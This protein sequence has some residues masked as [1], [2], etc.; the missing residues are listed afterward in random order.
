MR[1]TKRKELELIKKMSMQK[2]NNGITLIALVVTVIVLL[3]LAGISI[4]ML[5]G[6]NG[7]LQRAG[8]AKD[9]TEKEGAREQIGLE[10]L[11]ALDKYGEVNLQTLKTK[12][13]EINADV[14]SI[15]DIM[16]ENA[17]TGKIT[18]NGYDFYVD[19]D[20]RVLDYNGPEGTPI[21]K[22]STE[23]AFDR[24][25][26]RIDI[27]FLNGTGYNIT[28]TPNKPALDNTMVPVYYDETNSVWKVCS[29]TD[30]IN[31]YKYE[32]EDV[33]K[34]GTEAGDT[35]KNRWANVMLTDLIQVEKDGTTYTTEQIKTLLTENN[36]NQIVG[37]T[38]TKEGSMLVW[39]P[40]YAYKITYYSDTAKTNIIGYSDS[41][42][43][44][45]P[46]GTYPKNMQEPITSINVNGTIG[47]T[48]YEYYRPHPAFETDLN[49]G[50]WSKKITGIWV[51]KFEAT[52][53]TGEVT[54]LSNTVA[55]KSLT[56]G[57]LWEALK[58][59][60]SFKA[61]TTESH[62]MKNSEW[63]A[64]SYLAE[65]KFGRNEVPITINGNSDFYTGD[66]D[67]K[68]NEKQKQSTTGNIYGVYDTVGG[69]LEYVAGYIPNEKSAYGNQFASTDGTKNNKKESTQ[70][71]TVYKY[72]KDSDSN[73]NNYAF[74]LNRV[75]GDGICETSTAGK[76]TTSWH[77][78]GSYFAESSRP[79][80]VRGGYF[81]H[82]SAGSF[83]F[84]YY[85]GNSGSVSGSRVVCVVK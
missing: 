18:L 69:I 74:S 53:T 4:Q 26:G 78:A 70:Y 79:F 80:F 9:M 72:N 60:N 65:S 20:N 31:W 34:A 2:R 52:G 82:S 47:T 85:N 59:K 39:I 32:A 8:Q 61:G 13:A 17:L 67:Y 43:F 50:G 5:T 76:E 57:T 44:V 51:G 35:H 14:T 7:I 66:R 42:G 73:T 62:M 45:H 41:R 58:N 48:A 25:N 10:V 75:F 64:C 46:D 1:N 38:V 83:F 21:P 24:A 37:G 28:E 3:I 33:S 30:T 19:N 84:N 56:T 12:L 11:G 81:N 15:E 77:L 54:T 16:Q 29:D 49:Q 40:R 55:L 27:V 68:N 22:T 71:S 36:L 23:K 63:G 6:D